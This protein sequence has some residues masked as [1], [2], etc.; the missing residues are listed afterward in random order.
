MSFEEFELKVR[1]SFGAL[2]NPGQR[3]VWIDPNRCDGKRYC[4]KTNNGMFVTGNS[5]SKTISVYKTPGDRYPTVIP[6]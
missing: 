2:I 5:E 6:V 3:N 4:A 1:K